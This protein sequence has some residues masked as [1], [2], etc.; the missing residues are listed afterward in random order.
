MLPDGEEEEEEEE[1]DT[2]LAEKDGARRLMRRQRRRLLRFGTS[3]PIFL[4]AIRITRRPPSL[5]RL[6]SNDTTVSIKRE[7]GVLSF[8]L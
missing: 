2:M 5:E 3:T 8:L 7:F 1:E 6:E 4:C